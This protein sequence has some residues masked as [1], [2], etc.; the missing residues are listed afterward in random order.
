MLLP[1]LAEAENASKKYTVAFRGINYGEGYQDG[2][3][4]ECEN[5][6]TERYPCI[7]PRAERS[8]KAQFSSPSSMHAKDGIIVVD[9]TEV[10][11]N[12]E[13]VGTVT[14]GRKQ[15]A[16]IG[17]YVVIF[18]DKAYF[19]VLTKTFGSLEE[20]YKGTGLKF[21][22]NTITTT[23]T[24]NFRD[25]DAVTISGCATAENNKSIIIRSL[26]SNTLTFKDNSFTAA[27]ETGEV[28]IKRKV[29]DLEFIC[30]SNYRLWGTKGNTIFSSKFSDPFNFEVFDGLADDS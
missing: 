13:P 16:T 5:L 17:N 18:P 15:M 21:T 6:S 24:F 23:G 1:Y 3:M 25:G 20:T 14:E 9:G 2:E 19:N 7:S 4:E 30:E 12:G 10:Y 27:T 22:H 11:F 28:T 26:T 29:P 8:V